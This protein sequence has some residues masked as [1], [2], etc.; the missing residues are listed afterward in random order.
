MMMWVSDDDDV[1][2]DV[3]DND[4]KD[5]EDNYDIDEV[6][7]EIKFSYN[8]WYALDIY[9][10]LFFNMSLLKGDTFISISI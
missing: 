8:L 7:H 1:S 2:D 5:D 4:V 6:S 3:S 10:T 9:V